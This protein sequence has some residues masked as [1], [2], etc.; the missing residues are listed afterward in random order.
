[1][2]VVDSGLSRLCVTKNGELKKY[3][4]HTKHRGDLCGE[5]VPAL[6]ECMSTDSRYSGLALSAGNRSNAVTG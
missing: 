3:L 5:L 1:M 6:W 4:C 2:R